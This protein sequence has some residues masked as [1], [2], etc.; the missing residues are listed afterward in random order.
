MCTRITCTSCGK[1]SYAGCGRHV[2]QVLGNV[3][4]EKRCKCREAD[5]GEG[6]DSSSILRRLFGG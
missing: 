3:P 2:E 4:P 6:K 1:P 5:E